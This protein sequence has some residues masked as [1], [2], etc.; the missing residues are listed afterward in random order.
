MTV[1]FSILH[2]F[3]PSRLEMLNAGKNNQTMSLNVSLTISE[4]TVISISYINN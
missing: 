3:I 1:Q 2:V 4:F